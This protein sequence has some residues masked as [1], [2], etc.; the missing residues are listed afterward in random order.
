MPARSTSINVPDCPVFHVKFDAISAITAQLEK[1]DS[2]LLEIKLGRLWNL[3]T[4]VS[5]D[6]INKLE[7]KF[8][9][10]NKFHNFLT[11]NTLSNSI[12]SLLTKYITNKIKFKTIVTSIMSKI[13]T[14]VSDD[15]RKI[16]GA[17]NNNIIFIHYKT[18]GDI[19]DIGR[20][21]IVMVDKKSGFDFENVA[22]TP[23]KLSPIDT[24]ALR[25]AALFDLTL[26]QSSYP[27]NNSDAYVKFIQ[28]KSKGDFFKDSLGCKKDVDN[29]KSIQQIFDA[30]I[31]F[32]KTEGLTIPIRDKI[33]EAITVLLNK[34]AKDKY[35]QS[36]TL[37]IVQKNIDKCIP[38]EH[39]AK[40][41]FITFVNVNEYQI[42]EVFE[43]TRRS[44]TD[45]NT[46]KFSDENDNFSVNV[47]KA[48][49]GDE[50]S[51]K[52]VKIDKNNKCLML[53]L[54]DFDFDEIM[55]VVGE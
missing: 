13:K 26:F 4:D 30:I 42:D 55:K 39:P 29:N 36:L 45:A 37:D 19:T 2:G 47:K 23:K 49:I 54:S 9:R 31:A 28:G 52:P 17:A 22:L 15:G 41:Q 8:R 40:G 50:K 27:K 18:T 53:P 5:T 46:F 24:D 10:K 20:L 51:S 16:S 48:A 35:D 12:P 11:E 21:L 25:Q 14:S 43:P 34:K 1:N 6:F 3:K 32:S 33:N 44:A 7:S 38:D